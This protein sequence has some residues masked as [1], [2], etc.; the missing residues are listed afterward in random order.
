MLDR[1]R[2]AA[3]ALAQKG[4]SPA[5]MKYITGYALML[6][7]CVAIYLFMTFFEW[8]RTGVPDLKEMR[9]MISTMVSGA[10]VAA[11][12]FVCKSY[13]DARKEA[14]HVSENHRP[15]ETDPGGEKDAGGPAVNG[16]GGHRP[17]GKEGEAP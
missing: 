2:K 8:Y 3:L 11:V 13:A 6:L 17:A 9:E 4:G 10:F 15:D 1:I 5:A 16:G 7:G 12:S 14:S